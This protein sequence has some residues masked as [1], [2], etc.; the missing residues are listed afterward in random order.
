MNTN[1]Q[2]QPDLGAPTATAVANVKARLQ[3]DYE[4]A[5]PQLAEI[6]HLVIDEEEAN[7]NASELS[8]PQLF[9]PDLV[10]AHI[11]KLNLEPVGASHHATAARRTALVATATDTRAAAEFRTEHPELRAA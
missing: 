10:A 5:Y 8:F 4:A 2:Y 1:P 7:A 9:L 11:E 3:H 6:I